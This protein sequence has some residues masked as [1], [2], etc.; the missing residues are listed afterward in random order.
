MTWPSAPQPLLI[1]GLAF[2]TSC[3]INLP[4]VVAPRTPGPFQSPYVIAASGANTAVFVVRMTDGTWRTVQVSASGAPVVQP[5]GNTP[6]PTPAQAPTTGRASQFAAIADFAGNGGRGVALTQ[7]GAS[8]VQVEIANPDF[9]INPAFARDVGPGTVSVLAVDLNGDGKP[10]IVTACLGNGSTPAAVWVSPNSGNGAFSDA[11]PYPA[12]PA[13]VSMAA[14][15]LNGDG[16]VDL[17]VANQSAGGA[18][19]SLTFLAG[20]GDG[21]FQAPATIADLGTDTPVSVLAADLNGDGKPDL[22]AAFTGGAIGVVKVFFGNGDGTFQFPASY[23]AGPR[24]TYLAAGD[25]NNDGRLDLVTAN[26]GN[27]TVSILLAN[28]D[29]TFQPRPLPFE[30]AYSPNSLVLTDFNGDGNL[31]ILVGFGNADCIGPDSGSGTIA[32]L[33][34]LGNGAFQSPTLDPAGTAPVAATAADLK[35]DGHPDIVTA[36]P[37]NDTLTILLAAAGGGFRAPVSLALGPGSGVAPVSVAAAD[38]NGDGKIDLAAAGSSSGL[39][40]VLRGNGDGTFQTAAS[41]PAAPGANHILAADL[42]GDGKTDLVV[43]NQGPAGGSGSVSVLLGNGDGTFHPAVNCA[44]GS[45]PVRVAAADFDGDGKID[46]AVADVGTAASST[47]TGS[48][49]ILLGRGD[50]TFRPAVKWAAGINPSLVVAGD[51][52]GDGKPDLAVAR[53]DASGNSLIDVWLG[54][55]DGTFQTKASYATAGG[56]SDLRAAD[57]GGAG[58]LSLIVAHC[59]GVN[60]TGDLA[61]NGDGTFQ[62]E[63]AV[64]AGPSAPGLAVADLDGDGRLDLV[65]ANNPGGQGGVSVLL[66]QAPGAASSGLAAVNAAWPSVGQTIAPDSIASLFGGRLAVGVVQAGA[67][68]ANLLGTTV[69]VKD[70]AGVTR[71]ASIYYVSPRQVNFLMPAGTASGAASVTVTAGDGTVAAGTAQIASVAPGIFELDSAGLA[72]ATVLTVAADGGQQTGNVYQVDGFGNIAPL[73]IALNPN[74]QVYLQLFGTGMRH[75]Q[76]V[77]AT[78]GGMSVPLQSFGPS[79]SPG[80]DQINLGPL[81]AALA[82]SGSATLQVTADGQKANAVNVTFQ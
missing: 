4:V 32:V 51:W 1:L 34:G 61:G 3:G 69:A 57:F 78:V 44:A 72:A 49:E 66:N 52:N 63:N 45:H 16:K 58:K 48:L 23:P 22:A 47:D 64:P 8:T 10:E 5:I 50:G 31:D 82:G 25:F 56:L 65:V 27:G 39:V 55:G 2:L 7:P 29:G 24:P 6:A 46:L 13:P 9:S 42:N 68:V 67:P 54:N 79:S 11:N 26:G 76:N 19:A 41:Y 17:V 80:E 37:S 74:S 73:P 18:D 77:S 12:G 36:N 62:A 14:A 20:N 75:A 28:A 30:A 43:A 81:P 15:D 59:C 40:Y 21:T 53:L 70:S 38:F 35:G 33:Y 71:P 60:G